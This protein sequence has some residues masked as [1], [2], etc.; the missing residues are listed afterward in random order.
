M[1]TRLL[2]TAIMLAAC[3]G[4]A[5]VHAQWATQRSSSNGS[6]LVR[7][8]LP[9]S[10]VDLKSMSLLDPDRFSMKQQT[11]MS[12]SSSNMTG[13][14]L[15][16]MYVNTMEYRFKMPLTMR[17]KVAYQNN[18]GALIGNRSNT[19]QRLDMDMGNVFVPAFDIVYQPWKNT[20]LS[21]IYRDYSGL[22]GSGSGLYSLSPFSRYSSDPFG[23]YR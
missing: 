13:G 23:L 4:A 19:G 18:M 10:T 8:S 20:T 1:R 21:F 6:S 17:L 16:G 7:T 9:Q 12:Y 14:N 22:V 11:I 15:L 3:A 5:D 2:V